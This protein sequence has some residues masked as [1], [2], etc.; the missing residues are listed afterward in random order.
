MND[1]KASGKLHGSEKPV[2]LESS[3]CP[4][5]DDSR[6]L[7]TVVKSESDINFNNQ[8]NPFTAMFHGSHV[9]LRNSRGL[10]QEYD[11]FLLF[12]FLPFFKTT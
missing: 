11:S 12:Y 1:A 3:T 2:A 4:E 9:E 6:S 7:T 10:V 8:I 5:S